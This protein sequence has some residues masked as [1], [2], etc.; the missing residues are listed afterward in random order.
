MLVRDI[1][2]QLRDKKTKLQP[3]IKT[4]KDARKRFQVGTGRG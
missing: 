1:T 3:E 4:L 2:Q